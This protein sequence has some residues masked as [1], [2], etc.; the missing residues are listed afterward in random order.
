MGL[1]FI[2]GKL[3]ILIEFNFNEFNLIFICLIFI[4]IFVIIILVKLCLYELG[5]F[6]L[7]VNI[8]FNKC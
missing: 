1:C 7:F 6:W 4:E 8:D 2:L 5:K 3:M